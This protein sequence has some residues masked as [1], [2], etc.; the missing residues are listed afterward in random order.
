MI[1]VNGFISAKVKTGG[2]LGENGNP[3]RPSSEW[4]EPIPCN[5]RVNKRNNLGKQN[6]NTFTVASYEILIEPQSFIDDGMVKLQY[7]SGKD[8][9]EFPIMFPPEFLEAVGAVKITV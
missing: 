6:G 1:I 2:G 9:G 3:V 7:V 8:L 4:G 5:I